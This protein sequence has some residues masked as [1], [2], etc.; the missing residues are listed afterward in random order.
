MISAWFGGKRRGAA[1]GI[2]L[3]APT[4]GS[5]VALT[6][7]NSILMPFFGSSWRLTLATYAGIAF[8]ACVLWWFIAVN[9]HKSPE[10]SERSEG[11]LLASFKV[12]PALL[13]IRAV[14][15]VLA[16]S[17]GVF[18]FGH[19]LRNWLP[20][21]LRMGGMSA[22]QAGFWAAAP[23]TIGLAGTLTVPRL[24]VPKRRI[25]ILVTVL[26]GASASAVIIATATGIPLIAGLL[27]SGL[28]NAGITPILMLTLMDSPQIG[29][30]RMG[31]AG[32]LYFTAGEIGG[33]SGPLLIGVLSDLTGNFSAGLFMLAGS[34]AILALL[35]V[36]LGAVIRRAMAHSPS[37]N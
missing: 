32:G 19:G 26:C 18:L 6:T 9:S 31:A 14:Q 34:S 7:A 24:A 29:S 13:R 23:A 21:I 36:W 3:T 30:G 15:I 11:G 20:E 25:P 12:F 27:L 10:A 33:V 5:V 28:A 17:L 1:M 37:G 8:L 16:M 35:A 22:K 4:V 2:Y